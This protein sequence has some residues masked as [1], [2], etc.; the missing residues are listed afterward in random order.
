MP[1]IFDCH[2]HITV[3]TVDPL[4]ALRTPLS[5]WAIEAADNGRRVLE[6]GVT[7]LR[8]AGGMD[9][10]IRGAFADGLARGPRAQISIVMLTQTGGHA[11]GF[12]PGAGIELSTS[13][14]FPDYPGRPPYLVD[15]ADEMRRTV[16]RI[17][18]AG[19]DWIKLATTGGVM[20]PTDDPERAELT[21]EEIEIAVAEAARHGKFVLAH[22]NAG[23]GLD[24]AVR[25]GV[26]SIEHGV[27]LNEGQAAAM[28]KKGCF[29]VP[30]L[31]IARDVMR[32]ADAGKLPP[33][34]AAK[35][36]EMRDRIGGAVAIAV[37]A[38]VKIATGAD[39]VTREQ[40]GR[41]LEEIFLL[42]EAGLTVPQ[43]LLAA[44]C[45]GAELCGV[46]HLYGRIAPG[47]VFD[48]VLLDEEPG[49]DLSMFDR[50][51]AVTGVFKGGD[52]I[53]RHPRLATAAE[54]VSV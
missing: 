1:G 47:Y 30:T 42:R 36:N 23:E 37:A 9:A 19:A 12:L 16:R 44:T 54:A 24:N 8:D 5:R 10:G 38:G 25:A 2:A 7:F 33:Y 18:R 14:I 13:Y 26:R 6:V 21:L 53:L 45:N 34:A 41:N 27:Y 29:F 40:H 3:S 35:A 32:M 22:A 17:L 11:D 4:E 52:V 20:S 51:G 49:G 15:G 50:P 39:F 43:A 48:A 28:A 31:A 46:G